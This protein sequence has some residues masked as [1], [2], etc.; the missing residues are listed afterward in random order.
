MV[1]LCEA[2]KLTEDE[3]ETLVN[4][5]LL[6]EVVSPSTS[7]RDRGKKLHRYTQIESLEEYWIVEQVEALVTRIVRSE[8][9]WL[10]RFVRGEEVALESEALGVSIPLADDLRLG[11][12]SSDRP[13][14]LKPAHTETAQK[15]RSAAEAL[16][17]LRTS[18]RVAE[19]VGQRLG[20]RRLLQRPVPTEKERRTVRK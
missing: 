8:E 16:P 4:P 7:G 18:V 20:R 2:P 15:S 6:V 12:L 3:V 11:G 17:R 10:L 5:S 13:G 1:A 14:C 19:E 9:G